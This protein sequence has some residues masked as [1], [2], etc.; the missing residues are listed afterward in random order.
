MG[1]DNMAAEQEC[2]LLRESGCEVSTLRLPVSWRRMNR[3]LD[4]EAPDLVHVHNWHFLTSPFVIGAAKRRGIPVVLTPRNSRLFSA[5]TSLLSRHRLFAVCLRGMFPWKVA[6]RYLVVTPGARNVFVSSRVESPTSSFVVESG[7]LGGINQHESERLKHFLY[8]GRLSVEKGLLTLLKAFALSPYRLVILG[9]GPLLPSV[10]E[11]A[12][13]FSNIEYKGPED[14]RA[15][16]GECVRC[17]AFIFP[18][19]RCEVNP[20]T[21]IEALACGTAVIASRTGVM[22]DMITHGVNGLLFEPRNA[23]DL[24]RSLEQWQALSREEK[25]A[26]SE[27]ARESYLTRYTPEKNISDLLAIY[28]SVLDGRR[29][30]EGLTPSIKNKAYE[31]AV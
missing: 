20:L 13:H 18:G 30:K 25:Q 21:V 22:K 17:A 7:C 29:A 27:R 23:H 10:L 11:Y 1:A 26:Y 5:I 31:K 16:P 14:Q 6:A 2:R 24:C 19:I 4:D 8:I 9:D 3:W 28:Q 15:V 12:E